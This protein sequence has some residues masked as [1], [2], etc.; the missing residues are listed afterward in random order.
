MGLFGLISETASGFQ[1]VSL[2]EQVELAREDIQVVVDLAGMLR[3]SGSGRH[4]LGDF[5]TLDHI[6]SQ[7]E[8]SFLNSKIGVVVEMVDDSVKVFVLS[9]LRVVTL[10]YTDENKDAAVGDVLSLEV[11]EAKVVSV[12]PLEVRL[13]IHPVV[14]VFA[15]YA[16][17][18]D[19][20]RLILRM[21]RMAENPVLS[22]HLPVLEQ[23]KRLKTPRFVFPDTDFN[24]LNIKARYFS[25]HVPK[26]SD[27]YDLVM[28]NIQKTPFQISNSF[29][30]IGMDLALAYLT[31]K[32]NKLARPPF[33]FSW[34]G[35]VNEA[36]VLETIRHN[37]DLRIRVFALS[38]GV[39]LEEGGHAFAVIV[40]SNRRTVDRFDS[41][42]PS[43]LDAYLA[44]LFARF[45]P[46]YEYTA[47]R[48][49]G[50]QTRGR[51]YGLDRGYCVLWATLLIELSF[52]NPALSVD[53]ILDRMGHDIAELH[54]L[55][56]KYSRV[57]VQFYNKLAT[58]CDE[59]QTASHAIVPYTALTA[60]QNKFLLECAFQFF[61]NPDVYPAVPCAALAQP[62]LDA[63]ETVARLAALYNVN[64]EVDDGLVEELNRRSSWHTAKSRYGVAL[65][66][67]ERN[68][69][70]LTIRYLRD[71][72]SKNN[73]RNN[74]NLFSHAFF[75]FLRCND[76]ATRRAKHPVIQDSA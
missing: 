26:Y 6:H 65:A 37:L 41:E 25:R 18:N 53:E 58:E 21:T 2:D 36:L 75:R 23:L 3:N 59:L 16:Q 47:P 56:L 73:T 76:R 48:V 35:N 11:G 51:Q 50:I 14:D 60:R 19:P 1:G 74:A 67:T 33:Q 61:G 31:A 72:L 4:S 68:R 38:F 5:V 10:S 44:Q 64:L 39:D 55:L 57:F 27:K 17:I 46:D 30:K 49:D 12:E 70:R 71:V 62:N 7:Q 54:R 20:A 8:M 24:E 63:R 45:L 34:P 29:K 43:Q 32:H 42:G 9:D 22:S 13:D 15:R 69:P 40:N 52:L 28:P 66:G